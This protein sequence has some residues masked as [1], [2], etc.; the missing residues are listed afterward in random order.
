MTGRRLWKSRRTTSFRP[1]RKLK[2]NK[3]AREKNKAKKR[4]RFTIPP[5]HQSKRHKASTKEGP[6][7]DLTTD[8]GLSTGSDDDIQAATVIFQQ[9]LDTSAVKVTVRDIESLVD[10]EGKLSDVIVMFGLRHFAS[11]ISDQELK[12][13]DALAATTVDGWS[14]AGPL[15]DDFEHFLLPVCIRQHWVLLYGCKD[16]D[17]VRL[18]TIDS[19]GGTDLSRLHRSLRGYFHSRGLH[20][21]PR[22]CKVPTQVAINS[23]GLRDDSSPDTAD[24]KNPHATLT[25]CIRVELDQ[26]RCRK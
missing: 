22:V 4:V 11:S 23:C 20:V 10:S 3:G 7:L 15:P 5:P 18:W 16:D 25:H 2:P 26:T 14:N 17:Q 9:N 24:P 13:I 19:V 1:A 8:S 6:L 12:I 21:V